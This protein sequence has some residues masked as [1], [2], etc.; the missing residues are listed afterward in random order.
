MLYLDVEKTLKQARDNHADRKVDSVYYYYAAGEYLR[1]CKQEH[2]YSRFLASERYGLKA[3]SLA[4]KAVETSEKESAEYVEPDL[5][6]FKK[7][8]KNKQKD[9]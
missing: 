4:R 7:T 1:K 6:S 8:K 2:G 3:K 5:K 9:Q